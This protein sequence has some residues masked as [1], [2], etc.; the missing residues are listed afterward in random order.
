MRL[1]SG[2]LVCEVAYFPYTSEQVFYDTGAGKFV[3]MLTQSHMRLR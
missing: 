1:S 3:L 2:G